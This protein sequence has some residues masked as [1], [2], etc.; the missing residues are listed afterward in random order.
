MAEEEVFGRMF[1]GM[2]WEQLSAE[3]KEAYR[4]QGVAVTKQRVRDRYAVRSKEK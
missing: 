2:N 1:N 4:Q 3:Q